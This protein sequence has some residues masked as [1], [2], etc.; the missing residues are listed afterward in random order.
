[1]WKHW[2]TFADAG[3]TERNQYLKVEKFRRQTHPLR[4]SPQRKRSPE[5]A[6]P[7]LRRGWRRNRGYSGRNGC[8][9]S[10]APNPITWK[11]S[12]RATPYRAPTG[13]RI[14]G[15][16]ALRTAG[17]GISDIDLLDLYSCL[18]VAPELVAAELDIRP[19]R[20][21]TI[22]GGMSFA[23]GPYNS[24]ALHA[25]GQR[26]ERLRS[27]AGRTG[28]VGCIFGILTKQGF[29]VWSSK[30]PAARFT[31]SDLTIEV[32]EAEAPKI[33]FAGPAFS[34]CRAN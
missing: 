17:A 8:S 5:H 20:P 27:G 2:L 28:I 30:P 31:I 22:A 13:A 4:H 32:A 15:E 3:Q 9:R 26:C 6:A 1:M 14:A 10:R 11:Q 19:D 7:L 33:V 34:T 24:S 29:G 18:P 25:T 16:V 21:L 12:P 23:G